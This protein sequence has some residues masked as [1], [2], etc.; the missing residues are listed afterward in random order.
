MEVYESLS[1]AL[2][3]RKYSRIHEGSNGFVVKRKMVTV[4]HLGQGAAGPRRR[5]H[6]FRLRRFRLQFLTSARFLTSLKETCLKVMAGGSKSSPQI[7][8]PQTP[9]IVMLPKHRT[10]RSSS[11]EVVDEGWFNRALRRSIAEGRITI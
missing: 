10:L 6:R 8:S 11:N 5:A 4:A 2:M 7:T 9:A 1:R 3:R